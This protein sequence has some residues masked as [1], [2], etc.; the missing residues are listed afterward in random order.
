M[1]YCYEKNQWLTDE[2]Q[3]QTN[4]ILIKEEG[5][6]AGRKELFYLMMHLSNCIYSYIA[7]DI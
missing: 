5:R 4:S 2:V 7:L 6:K 3:S 1:K